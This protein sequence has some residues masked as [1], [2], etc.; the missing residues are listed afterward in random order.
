WYLTERRIVVAYLAECFEE[1]FRPAAALR[2]LAFDLAQHFERA[3]QSGAFGASELLNR[4]PWGW[5]RLREA[6][7][8]VA[9]EV[10]RSAEYEILKGN[11]SHLKHPSLAESLGAFL[12]PL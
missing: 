7:V 8:A 12:E 6:L 3:R 1:C 4:H 2:K 5:P 9:Q 10:P 11:W